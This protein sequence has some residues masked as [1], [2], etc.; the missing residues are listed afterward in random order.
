MRMKLV[1]ACLTAL[2]ATACETADS[3]HLS[4][5]TEPD[6]SNDM[7]LGAFSVSLAVKDLAASRAFY[8]KLGFEQFAGEASPFLPLACPPDRGSAMLRTSGAPAFRHR[9]E[10]FLNESESV[11]GRA[12]RNPLRHLETAWMRA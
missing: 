6:R 3:T 9:A 11:Y 2:A 12:W 7:D 5:T 4:P 1:L 10:K 8:E